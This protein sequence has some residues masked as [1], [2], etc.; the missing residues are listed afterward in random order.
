MR[1]YKR[2]LADVY[3]PS[4]PLGVQEIEHELC[5][6]GQHAFTVHCANPGGMHGLAQLHSRAWL[7]YSENPKRKLRYSLELVESLN[8]AIVC[9]NTARANQ[10]IAEALNQGQIDQ[11]TDFVFK[12]EVTW[13]QG[14][15]KSRFDFAFYFEANKPS[16]LCG[17]IEVKSVTYAPDPIQNPG[18]VAFPDSVTSR[19]LKHLEAL[20]KVLAEGKRAILCF[21]VNR[22]DAEQV[23]IAEDIDP[24]YGQGMRKAV[25]AGVE[26]IALKVEANCL[27]QQVVKILPFIFK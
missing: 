13:G 15:H 16:S 11:L 20:I 26:I 22:N 17:Y 12:P 1:R 9:V 24:A 6:K 27:G 2:F 5:P 18:L 14:E 19:G 3:A 23:S 21:C 25:D 8:Q 4:L 7:Y 10:V